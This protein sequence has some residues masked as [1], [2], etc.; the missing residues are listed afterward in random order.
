[1]ERERMD[2]E[3]YFRGMSCEVA[4]C[5]YEEK[6]ESTSLHAPRRPHRL[7]ANPAFIQVVTK[8]F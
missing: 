1:M 2:L 3:S 4:E 5:V 6:R 8:T 7:Y